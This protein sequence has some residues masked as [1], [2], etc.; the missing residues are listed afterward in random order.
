MTG[1]FPM[2][3]WTE[4]TLWIDPTGANAE[5]ENAVVEGRL[6]GQKCLHFVRSFLR[7]RLGQLERVTA[8]WRGDGSKGIKR[9]RYNVK[10]QPMMRPYP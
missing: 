10:S 6:S 1:K 3:A 9:S 4:I 2:H 8:H 7:W 5:A